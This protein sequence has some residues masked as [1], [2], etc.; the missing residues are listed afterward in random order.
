MSATQSGQAYFAAGEMDRKPDF[1]TTYQAA[2]SKALETMQAAIALCVELKDD[3]AL[4]T[5]QEY[6][7]EIF[8]RASIARSN[9]VE[10]K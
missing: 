6:C 1:D 4:T 2:L 3:H 10:F 9:D 7:G 5:M 8:R